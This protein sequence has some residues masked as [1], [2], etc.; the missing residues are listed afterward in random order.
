MSVA[1]LVASVESNFSSEIRLRMSPAVFK[2]PSCTCRNDVASA[3]LVLA[4]SVRLMAA[5]NFIETARPPASSAGE[6]I[7]E[8][9]DKRA[10]LFWSIVLLLFRLYAA[11]I[12]AAFV[13]MYM[14]MF[15]CYLSWSV[16]LRHP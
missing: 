7:R 13:L 2:A 16:W 5:S 10:R 12:A 9:L 1:L 8:P 14:P 3:T 6:T 15:G 4:A 11:L